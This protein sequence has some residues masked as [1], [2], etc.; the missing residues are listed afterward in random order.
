M[1]TTQSKLT[2]VSGQRTS[3]AD[4]TRANRDLLKVVPVRFPADK[5]EQIM[6]EVNELGIG[7]NTLARIWR[8]DSLRRHLGIK[9]HS[10]LG[11]K[12][13]NNPIAS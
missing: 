7:P 11:A 1:R 3:K 6:K 12:G 5:W 8:L 10:V 2:M 13:R 9:I 4:H